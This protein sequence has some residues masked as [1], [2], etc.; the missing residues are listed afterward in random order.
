MSILCVGIGLAKNAYAVQGANEAG[1]DELRPPKTSPARLHAFIVSLQPRAMNIDACSG[2][3][4][5]ARLFQVHGRT[6][7]QMTLKSVA[8]YRMRG[9]QGWNDVTDALAICEAVQRP[10][11]RFVAIKAARGPDR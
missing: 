6:V 10:N 5:W 4:H 8:P 2:A 11:M 1:A 7:H 3:H 9:R